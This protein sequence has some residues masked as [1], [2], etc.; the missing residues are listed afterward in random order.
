[1]IDMIL[2]LKRHTLEKPHKCEE[3]GY[4]TVELSKLRRHIRTHT[5]VSFSIVVK[6]LFDADHFRKNHIHVHIAPI[7]VRIPLNSNDIYV[8]IQVNVCILIHPLIIDFFSFR[9]TTLSVHGNYLFSFWNFFHEEFFR[10]ID[11]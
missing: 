7:A 11:L 8:F 10:C 1:M 5:G 9:R 3:C 2:L 6:S 4:A